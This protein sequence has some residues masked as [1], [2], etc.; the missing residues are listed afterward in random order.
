MS[1][2]FIE[3]LLLYIHDVKMYSFRMFSRLRIRLSVSS[4]GRDG[5]RKEVVK[6]GE[7]GGRDGIC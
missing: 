3:G 2:F 7:R 5:D 6:V 1:N 4:Y